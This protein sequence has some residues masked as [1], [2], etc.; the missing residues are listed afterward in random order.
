MSI[1]EQIHEMEI[2][3]EERK[4]ERHKKYEEK[5]KDKILAE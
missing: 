1:K 4:E 5:A 2:Y 3:H